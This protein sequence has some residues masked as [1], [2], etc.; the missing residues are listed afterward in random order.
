MHATAP[1]YQRPKARTRVTISPRINTNA[2]LT[3]IILAMMLVGAA[4]LASEIVE[5]TRQTDQ[6]ALAGG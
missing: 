1:S 6:R 4:Y 2:I 3:A 5:H